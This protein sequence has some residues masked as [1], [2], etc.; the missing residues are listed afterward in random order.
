MVWPSQVVEVSHMKGLPLLYL[1][2]KSSWAQNTWG[3]PWRPRRPL[4][5]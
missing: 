4:E 3:I 1:E 5:T 2:G